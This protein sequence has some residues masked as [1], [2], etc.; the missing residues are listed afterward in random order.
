MRALVHG[1]IEAVVTIEKQALSAWKKSQ[2]IDELRYAHSLVL[3]AEAAG[4][5]AGWCC[6]RFEQ[7]EAELLKVAVAEKWRRR[8]VATR[9]LEALEL[10]LRK[11][12]VVHLFLEVR[13]ENLPA[14]AFYA[15]AGFTVTGRRINYYSQPSDNALVM[16]KTTSHT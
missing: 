6:C 15:K 1:D 11:I 10:E 7:D 4:E 16:R 14:R 5:L 9:L 13:S 2:I 12:N 8:S 3:A